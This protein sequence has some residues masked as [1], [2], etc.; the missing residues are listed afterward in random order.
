MASV[1]EMRE[2]LR[3]EGHDVPARGR[4]R[5]ELVDVYEA[6]HPV[7]TSSDD[8]WDIADLDDLAGADVEDLE[9]SVPM[10]P[11]RRPRTERSSRQAARAR[12]ARTRTDQ[13]VGKLLGTPKDPKKAGPKKKA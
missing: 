8:D 5:P 4:L 1:T 13:W 3:G 2:W 12:P 7:I 10:T 9:P 11:E 6:A